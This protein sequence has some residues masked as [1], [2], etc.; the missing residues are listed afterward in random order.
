MQF[1]FNITEKALTEQL[2]YINRGSPMVV[3]GT[4][5]LADTINVPMAQ[6][7]GE[8]V[9][10]FKPE[11]ET[12]P[13]SLYENAAMLVA[14]KSIKG[15]WVTPYYYPTTNTQLGDTLYTVTLL[16]SQPVLVASTFNIRGNYTINEE[17][18]AITFDVFDINLMFKWLE[19]ALTDANQYNYSYN[20][21]VVYLEGKLYLARH[22]DH[23]ITYEC[24]TVNLNAFIHM[25]KIDI[26]SFTPD[27]Y[28]RAAKGETH[29]IYVKGTYVY[30]LSSVLYAF[31][32]GDEHLHVKFIKTK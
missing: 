31:M 21:E 2:D 17:Q 30:G 18:E 22:I 7:L 20:P 9:Q 1:P 16:T 24:N 4:F 12:N 10:T 14:L 11:S 6:G 23:Q 32:R 29:P 27:I 25:Y 19:G 3:D 28:D 15:I 8:R 13:D 26:T 5:D